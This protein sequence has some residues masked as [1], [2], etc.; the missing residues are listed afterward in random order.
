MTSYSSSSQSSTTSNTSPIPVY[1]DL[2]T[3][4]KHLVEIQGSLAHTV[5]S[6]YEYL[7]LGRIEKL[8]NENYT[9][10][11]GNHQISGKLIKLK[12]PIVHCEKVK[13]NDMDNNTSTSTSNKIIIK[14]VFKSKIYFNGRP[15]PYVGDSIDKSLISPTKKLKMN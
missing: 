4:E 11:V 6:K 7:H 13:E 3:N 8:S 15:A 10:Y 14:D 5:E 12:N 9:L 1:I 2:D